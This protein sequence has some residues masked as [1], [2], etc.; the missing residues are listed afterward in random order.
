MTIGSGKQDCKDSRKQQ[1]T[2]SQEQRDRKYQQPKS[3]PLCQNT[4]H[5]ALRSTGPSGKFPEI[6]P[7]VAGTAPIVIGRGVVGA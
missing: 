7:L 2:S 1:E 4:T 6:I 5:A 3:N